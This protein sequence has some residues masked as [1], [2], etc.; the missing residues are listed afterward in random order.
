MLSWSTIS[1]EE[2]LHIINSLP[3]VR[4]VEARA[5]DACQVM[6]LA[7]EHTSLEIVLEKP[8]EMN[9]PLQLVGSYLNIEI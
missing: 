6:C 9:Y 1:R 5:S 8:F 3:G 4:G 2:L 7:C